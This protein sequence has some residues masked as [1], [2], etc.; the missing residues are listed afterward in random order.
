MRVWRVAT[1]EYTREVR[2]VASVLFT[3]VTSMAVT[4]CGS[5]PRPLVLA[6]TTSVANSGLLDVLLPAF[7]RTS[8]VTASSQLVGSGLALKM[9]ADGNADVAITHEPPDGRIRGAPRA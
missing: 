3:F 2:S 8:G 6:T 9:L 5:G 7:E 4:A 1:S